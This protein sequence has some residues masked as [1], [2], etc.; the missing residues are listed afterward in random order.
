MNNPMQTKWS[1]KLRAFL[2]D[3]PEKAYDYGP[4]HQERADIHAAAFK[5]PVAELP[6][7]HPDW[8][9][10][11]ADRFIFPKGAADCALGA[12]LAFHHPFAGGAGKCAFPSQAEAEQWI[13]DC[14]PDFCADLTSAEQFWL[15]WRL[16]MHYSADHHE[17]RGKGAGWLAYLP[18]DTR[19]PDG[20][21]W[22]HCSIVSALES[23]RNAQNQLRPAFMLFQLGPVQ[24]FIAQARSIRDL[25]SGSYLLAWLMAHAIK[26]VTDDLGPDAV[27]FPSLRGQPL[28]DWLHRDVLAKARHGGSDNYWAAI[29][30]DGAGFQQQILTP[31]L[32]NR[33]LAIVPEDYDPSRVESALQE[34]WRTIAAACRDFLRK[35]VPAPFDPHDYWDFQ[36]A[37]HWQTTWQV[38]PW[39]DVQTTIRLASELPGDMGKRLQDGHQIAMAIPKDQKDNRCYRENGQPDPGWAWAGHYALAAHRHD[40]RR[41]ARDFEAWLA[42]ERTR[43]KT[44]DVYSGR[45]ETVIDEDWLKAAG[46][47]QALG[48]LF[49]NGNEF[50][51]AVNLIKRIWHKAYL[52]PRMK[53]RR[54]VAFDSV[55]AVAAEPWK[56]QVLTRIPE[57][58]AAWSALMDFQSAAGRCADLLDFELPD[59]EGKESDWI[60][61]VDAGL[62]YESYWTRLAKDAGADAS[63]A[64]DAGR[65]L[66]KLFKQL[67]NNKPSAYYAVLALDGDDMGKWISGAKAPPIEKVMSPKAV[68]YFKNLAGGA[69]WL[70]MPRPVSPSYHLQFSEALANFG[71]HCARRIVERYDG[72]LIYAGGDDVLAM[73]PADSAIACAR[74]LRLA[75]RGDPALARECPRDFADAPD[76][77]VQIREPRAAEPS[78]PLLVPGDRATVSVGVAIAHVREPLQDVIGA[79]R[80]AERRAKSFPDKDA[81]AV[82]LFKRSGEIVEWQ[83][84]FDSC[85][86]ELFALLRAYY[87]RDYADPG[88]ERPI[89]ARLPYRLAGLLRRFEATNRETKA[90][91]VHAATLA[92]VQWTIHQIPGGAGALRERRREI[93]P[94]LL[95]G[96]RAYLDELKQR[97]R[98]LAEFYNLFAV[99]AFI[100]RQGE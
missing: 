97:Q 33:F 12:G 10:S 67:K 9:A 52:E 63:L 54:G 7:K 98:P 30:G 21:I 74:A 37:H 26:K 86:F 99:E 71:L 31:T 50:V 76:G 40:A 47:S 43:G 14:R 81:L 95:E 16:W 91:D 39:H 3:P 1:H 66:G 24:D 42:P 58:E 34:E 18:A 82:T 15:V 79:A 75:F 80:D 48:H 53:L 13:G 68:A 57:S 44:K 45:E 28:Y 5:V 65:A 89:P 25:W 88:A 36:V 46:S 61:K 27:I 70:A 72:Q 29:R 90:A 32:P 6:S 2:H 19:I 49:R 92:E 38:W 87:R 41:Q 77:F 69:E 64:A 85:C 59:A 35:K 51:G 22:T 84:R 20:T 96:C 56:Q 62:F 94:K 4:R 55:P 100:A 17:G 23:T 60:K 93:K 78:W 8:G 11:A 83:A 73:L